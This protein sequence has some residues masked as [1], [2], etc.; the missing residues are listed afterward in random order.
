MR[1]VIA[2]LPCGQALVRHAVLAYHD[3]MVLLGLLAEKDFLLS[4]RMNQQTIV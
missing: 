2:W 4:P 1:I 3:F